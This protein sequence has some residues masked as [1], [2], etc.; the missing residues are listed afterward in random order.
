MMERMNKAKLN[1]RR[2]RKWE[3]EALSTKSE[4][5]LITSITQAVQLSLFKKNFPADPRLKVHESCEDI[6]YVLTQTR[7]IQTYL[8]VQTQIFTHH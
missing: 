5:N 1:M 7:G 6:S 3:E 4:A 8:P 2:K